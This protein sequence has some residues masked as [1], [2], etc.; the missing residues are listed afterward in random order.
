MDMDNNINT[1]FNNKVNFFKGGYFLI[2]LSAFE[3]EKKILVPGH[4]FLPFL[5]PMIMPWEIKIKIKN[6]S[7]LK[8]ITEESHLGALKPLYSLF[9]EENILFLLI[10]DKEDNSEIILENEDHS[11]H[12]LYFTAYDLSPLFENQNTKNTL[13][14]L[15]LILKIDDWKKGIYTAQMKAVERNNI[16]AGEWVSRLEKGFITALSDNKKL[17]MLTEVMSDA[18]MYGGKVLLEDPAISLEDFFEISEISSIADTIL[19]RKEDPVVIEKK[20]FIREKTLSLI[21][22]FTAWFENNDEDKK[23]NPE[24]VRILEKQILMTKKTLIAVLEEINNPMLTE[25]MINTIMEIITESENLIS[26]IK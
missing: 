15:V 1:S 10:D 18:F 9:G 6:G 22:H 3:V 8:K 4:R 19:E 7:V 26:K 24:T 11:S 14:N 13:M 12:N 5:N 17:L 2:N 23:T 20:T 21:K 25:E 16:N